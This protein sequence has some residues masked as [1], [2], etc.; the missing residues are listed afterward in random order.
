MLFRDELWARVSPLLM[1]S[2]F[3]PAREQSTHISAKSL[4]KIRATEGDEVSLPIAT[5][6]RIGLDGQKMLDH[7]SQEVL[8]T[9]AVA[10]PPLE[11]RSQM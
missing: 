6:D 11:Q 9:L 10:T 4:T 8:C 1:Y 5:F 7:R 2:E 3:Q